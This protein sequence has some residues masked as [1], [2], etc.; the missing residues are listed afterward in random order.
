MLFVTP[1]V[2]PEIL[3]ANKKIRQGTRDEL[4]ALNGNMI[5]LLPHLTTYLECF[6]S[7]VNATRALHQAAY[8]AAVATHARL[9]KRHL[10]GDWAYAHV[11]AVDD[12]D[13]Q[14]L[15]V[16]RHALHRLERIRLRNTGQDPEEG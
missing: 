6:G 8:D 7:I 16:E 12:P 13:R 2:F 9:L 10:E 15:Q 4:A 1:Q 3:A 5:D 11:V 14:S